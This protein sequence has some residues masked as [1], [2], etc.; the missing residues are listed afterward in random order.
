MNKQ[1]MAARAA[2]NQTITGRHAGPVST[3]V[4]ARTSTVPGRPSMRI[5]RT[6]ARMTGAQ[7]DSAGRRS[8]WSRSTTYVSLVECDARW[9]GTVTR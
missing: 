1:T 5:R 2:A 6:K 9:S 4:S 3:D 7:R 8:D